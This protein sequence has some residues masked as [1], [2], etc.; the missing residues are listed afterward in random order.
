MTATSLGHLPATERW[1]FDESVTH[2]FD[3]MLARSIPQ[4]ETMR[5]TTYALGR[6]FVQ[7][8]THVLDLGCSN[9]TA[10]LPYVREFGADASYVGCEISPPMLDAARQSLAPYIAAGLVDIRE[11]DLRRSIPR[12]YSSL[13]LSVLTLMFVPIN[14]RLRILT[15]VYRYLK[16]GG[17]FLLVEKLLGSSADINDTMVDEYHSLKASNGYSQEE[18]TRKALALEGVQ[19]PLTAH[20]NEDLLRSAGFEQIDCYWRWMNFAAWIA[21]KDGSTR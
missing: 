9:G 15:D 14:Y 20:A 8:G 3:D 21:V 2:V 17:A 13:T 11:W 7:R 18:I 4:Y 1:E 19:V 6:R 12:V 10:L 16:P 5:E